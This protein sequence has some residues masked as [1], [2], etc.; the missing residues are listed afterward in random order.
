MENH[1]KC[2]KIGSPVTIIKPMQCRGGRSICVGPCG[3]RTKV[4]DLIYIYHGH[5]VTATTCEGSAGIRIREE[6]RQ[7]N[8]HNTC[9]YKTNEI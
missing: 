3:H 8:E 9:S 5:L 2:F 4:A 1:G 7:D 6:T